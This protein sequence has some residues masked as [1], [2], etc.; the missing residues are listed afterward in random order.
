MYHFLRYVIMLYFTLFNRIQVE[1][2]DNIPKT[3]AFLLFA[4]HPSMMDTFL[5]AYRIKRKVRYMA[6]AELFE[7]WI[8]RVFMNIA[9]AF[10]VHRGKGDV[11][12]IKSALRLLKKG[13]PVGIFPEGTRTRAKNLSK[14]KG[15]AAMVAIL[16]KAPIVPVGIDGRYRIFKKIRVVIGTPFFLDPPSELKPTR[17]DL[18]VANE[19]I[20]NRIYSLI[21]Q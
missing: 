5:V 11:G 15:G 1:G 9:G 12:A 16:S 7:S 14:K 20:I 21:G 19:I 4:N 10:P 17:E 3:G 2:L 13:E 6:K 8:I 18:H